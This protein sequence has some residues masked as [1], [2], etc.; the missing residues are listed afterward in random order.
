MINEHP[1]QQTE[2]RPRSVAV[3]ITLDFQLPLNF[4]RVWVLACISQQR[5]ILF[6]MNL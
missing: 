1:G 4:P 3:E 6:G 5:D 2:A